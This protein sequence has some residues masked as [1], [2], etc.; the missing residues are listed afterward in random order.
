MQ[1]FEHVLMFRLALRHRMVD[2]F[3]EHRGGLCSSFMK[4]FVD[5]G[6]LS[7][8]FMCRER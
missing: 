7:H 8:I 2:K 1:I 3:W 5:S 6:H 4:S